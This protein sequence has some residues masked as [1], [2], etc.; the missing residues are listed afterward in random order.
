MFDRQTDGRSEFISRAI[1]LSLK[2]KSFSRA[3]AAWFFRDLLCARC[4]VLPESFVR[5][6]PGSSG[7]SRALVAWFSNPTVR[8]GSAGGRSLPGF[9]IRH[10]SL[11]AVVTDRRMDRGGGGGV[12]HTHRI[13]GF[14]QFRTKKLK[15]KFRVFEN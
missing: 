12:L 10:F 4:L 7:I 11:R 14:E 3:L 9:R 5:S 15:I 2:V 6:L 8:A 13:G 1:S